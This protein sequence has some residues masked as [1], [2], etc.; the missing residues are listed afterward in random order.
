MAD[1]PVLPE[2]E[3][4]A[5]QEDSP[6]FTFRNDGVQY[7][8]KCTLFVV[9]TD[10][11]AIDLSQLRIVFNV[12]V[13]D[14]QSP[15]NAA[16]RVYNLSGDTVKKITGKTPVEYRRVVLSAGYENAAFGV[17][18]DGTIKQFRKGRED[19]KTSY[20]DILAADNDVG[21]NFGL[22][23]RTLAAGATPEQVC[24]VA[25]Q[26]MG[27]TKG[28]LSGLH[29]G[30]LV[31]LRPKVLYGMGREVLASV[32][33]TQGASW[34]VVN[35]QLQIL[36]LDSYLPGE[37]VDLNAQTGL[38]GIPEQTDEGIKVTALLNPK[39][40]IGGR[41]RLNND[42]INQIM[43]Q[44]QFKLPLGQFAFNSYAGMNF[45]AAIDADGFYRVLVAEHVGDT[46][47]NPWYTT[48]IGLSVD[49]TTDEV[50]PYG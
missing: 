6:P 50:A 24:D 49:P 2:V 21:Y 5:S 1:E 14:S 18:F 13:A 19:A 47:G 46:R 38:V 20:L 25:A 44:S 22:C 40:V 42:D 3:V 35:G 33:R 11:K 39:I 32:V 29:T 23:N 36:P 7:L 4:T 8:R 34:S 15:N 48:I 9:G 31:Y 41:I 12:Q 37:A 27:V 26:A 43:A 17:I 10:E 28:N 16:I 45:P 30:G